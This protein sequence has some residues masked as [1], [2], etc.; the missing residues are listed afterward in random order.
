VFIFFRPSYFVERHKIILYS[1][2]NQITYSSTPVFFGYLISVLD[3]G[4][5]FRAHDSTMNARESKPLCGD[6]RVKVEINCY[7]LFFSSG[8]CSVRSVGLLDSISSLRYLV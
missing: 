5:V 7:N 2:C 8:W 6:P 4:L 1:L 3:R